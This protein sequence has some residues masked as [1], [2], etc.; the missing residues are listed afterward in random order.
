MPSSIT[1]RLIAGMQKWIPARRIGRLIYRLSRSEQPWLK[2]RLIAGF[3][4]FYRVNRHE[5]E[6]TV[7]S[8]Y[9]SFNEFFTRKLAPG[10]RPMDTRPDSLLCPADGT[11]AQIGIASKQTLLQAKG[12]TFQSAELLGDT[13][14]ASELSGGSYATIYL[15]PYN[16]HRLHMPL[17]GT[18]EKTLFIPGR[19]YSV[20]TATTAT[21]PR[22]YALNERLVCLFR[23]ADGP[24]AMV[25]V[26]AMNVASIST[27]WAGEITT[28]ADGNVVQTNFKGNPHAPTL[29]RG[30]YMG[31]F[32][33]GSTIVLLAPPGKCTWESNAR[34]GDSVR[35]GQRLGAI[36]G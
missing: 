31:H 29:S 26:G 15:A 19:L 36:S 2:N 13:N 9:R 6:K 34:T 12:I 11:V 23:G 24:F 16:Y 4:W 8:G 18:L 30:D 35:V 1:H 17:N 7:P 27:A 28:P 10:A 33:M 25:L 32:N 3:A 21:I 5:A 22:L 20:S 14:M